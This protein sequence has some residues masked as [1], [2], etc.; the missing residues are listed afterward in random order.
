MCCCVSVVRRAPPQLRSRWPQL[1]T[2]A[3]AACPEL[4]PRRAVHHCRTRRVRDRRRSRRVA[5]SIGPRSAR[6]SPGST[7]SPRSELP[8]AATRF[9]SAA[10]FRG[11]TSTR[12]WATSSPK[13]RSAR[14]RG[15]RWPRSVAIFRCWTSNAAG[16]RS[17]ATATSIP[18]T[19]S[20]P[21]DG[22]VLLDW[23]LL[24]RRS[25]GVGSRPADDVD[26]TDGEVSQASTRR[27]P[28]GYGQSLRDDPLAE[29]I[30]ELRL[31]AATLMR[32]RAAQTDPSAAEEAELRLRYWRGES[33]APPWHAQ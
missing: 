18:A 13:S 21:A 9:R 11:G 4:R 10:T 27:L 20:S 14:G 32:V 1:L 31:V 3:R 22:P 29:A 7:A 28:Q 15:D 8:H 6:W 17:C 26:A 12:C 24:V 16:G 30:A 33:D 19:S 23:D 2:R 25:A 5:R